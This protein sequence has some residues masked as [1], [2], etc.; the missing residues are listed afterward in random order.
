MNWSVFAEV[1]VWA[2]TIVS[3]IIACGAL[4]VASEPMT[5]REA[6]NSVK[7]LIVSVIV[8]VIGV[9]TLAGMYAA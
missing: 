5:D 9:A 1:I 8:A 2:V 3:F 4:V 6:R 7:A